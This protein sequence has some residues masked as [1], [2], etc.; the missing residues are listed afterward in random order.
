MLCQYQLKSLVSLLDPSA[1]GEPILHCESATDPV[2][3][4][5]AAQQA[6]QLNPFSLIPAL[7]EVIDC[8]SVDKPTTALNQLTTALNQLTTASTGTEG[9]PCGCSLWV[10]NGLDCQSCQ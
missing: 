9:A 8:Y 7:L 3:G 6:E 4:A 2:A 1:P 10:A 5:T